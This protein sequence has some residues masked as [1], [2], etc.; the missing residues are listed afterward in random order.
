MLAIQGIMAALN[1][2]P[3][4]ADAIWASSLVVDGQGSGTFA[5]PYSL[6]GA[7]YNATQGKEI[8]LK[9]DGVY[10]LTNRIITNDDYD[11]RTYNTWTST[12][13]LNPIGAN[14]R[15]VECNIVAPTQESERITIR[16]EQYTQPTLDA[17]DGVLFALDNSPYLTFRALKVINA[18]A[19]FVVGDK[20]TD[21]RYIEFDL[22]DGKMST[23]GDNVGLIKVSD[24][25]GDHGKITRSIIE[26]PGLES[27]GVHGN[28]GAIYMRWVNHYTIDQVT[29]H[30]SP[31]SLYY[32]HPNDPSQADGGTP[33]LLFK[34]M[35]LYNCDRYGGTMWAFNNAFVENCIIDAGVLIGNIGGLGQNNVTGGNDN[36]F[37]NLTITG[38]LTYDENTEPLA[39]ADAAN[40]NQL[41][42][43]VVG[44]YS[45][46]PYT[47]SLTTTSTS[48]YNLFIND[49]I[50]H[51]G[52][53][54]TL[55]EWKAASVPAGQDVNSI[56][57][58]PTYKVT[59]VE[60][61][62]LTYALAINSFG[63][64][65][66][67]DGSDIG[68]N[69]L[70]VGTPV[71]NPTLWSS[72][73]GLRIADGV[74]P[75]DSKIYP[76]AAGKRIWYFDLDAVVDGNGDEATP[77][78]NFT[79]IVGTWDGTN[80][81]QGLMSGGDHLW[82]T[83]TALGSN[84]VQGVHDLFCYLKRD[85]Q[86]GTEKEPTVIR[87]WKGRSRAIFDGEYLYNVGVKCEGSSSTT[88]GAVMFNMEATRVNGIAFNMSSYVPY[89]TIDSC[90][91]HHNFA[92]A[93]GGAS[94][95]SSIL[96]INK[97]GTK[98]VVVRHCL[99][100]DNNTTDGTTVQVQNNNIGGISAESN[101]TA[102][103][104]STV[105][106]EYN[107]VFNE[108]YALRHKHSGAG[109]FISRFNILSDSI[110]GQYVRN[111]GSNDIH[112]NVVY[113]MTI[114][115]TT[116]VAENQ[117][118]VRLT[119]YYNNTVVN[120]P[121]MIGT[122]HTEV[123][124][125]TLNIDNN[126]YYN[127]SNVGSVISIGGYP[128]S[129]YTTIISSSNNIINTGDDSVMFKNNGVLKTFD[130][131]KTQTMD[132][133][134]VNEDPLLT[135]VAANDFRLKNYSPAILFNGQRLGAL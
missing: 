15:L 104:D 60:S 18:E 99:S 115:D 14:P 64:A 127:P 57:G 82:I 108:G 110:I 76:L 54:H 106:F 92:D 91:G 8:I 22:I 87:S 113:N 47:N 68:A 79:T 94:T 38:N 51:K 9:D 71:N 98:K 40:G 77:A 130:T 119:N 70:T 35:H 129:L 103:P 43:C 90:W 41:I 84:H 72:L 95:Y 30:N 58:S 74:E 26:G 11:D 23:G 46:W 88:G 3:N 107:R 45:N 118:V 134:S 33:T 86:L 66:G 50:V 17:Q 81:T 78:N 97:L 125:D 24:N 131:F 75:T 120:C 69:V 100:H 65:A 117:S 29:L 67:S 101:S 4:A 44:G 116:L 12:D 126:I 34:N 25:R 5:D 109:K 42:D 48:D 114:G 132:T 80:Y 49:S 96:V 89:G 122:S 124:Q 63:I 28:T 7:V 10:T 112:H 93:A 27:E 133:T 128:S 32:K 105:T 83:G 37:K 135:N 2:E 16:G 102:T 121:G 31:V 36:T 61:D 1:N 55:A 73:V 53:G 21:S 56:A 59:P 19:A 111:A 6:R 85:N 62:P 13:V 39:G 123:F 20:R 52:V